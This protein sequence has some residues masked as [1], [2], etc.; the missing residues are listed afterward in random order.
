MKWFKQCAAFKGDACLWRKHSL[1]HLST[2]YILAQ[3]N[4]DTW[5]HMSWRNTTPTFSPLV[6]VCKRFRKFSIRFF[7]YLSLSF[8]VDISEF[9][10]YIRPGLSCSYC[11]WALHDLMPLAH[12]HFCYLGAPPYLSV[13][14]T[15]SMTLSDHSLLHLHHVPF[16]FGLLSAHAYLVEPHIPLLFWALIYVSLSF[17]SSKPKHI[18]HHNTLAL[19]CAGGRT[20]DQLLASERLL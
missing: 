2:G 7:F 18:Y 9:S 4:S 13:L 12:P 15:L 17:L 3:H 20:L 11:S 19:A 8:S 6:F 5:A 10:C 16:L 1:R 14:L